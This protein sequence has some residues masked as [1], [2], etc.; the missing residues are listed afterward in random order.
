MKLKRIL[1]VLLA[2][3]LPLHACGEEA[4]SAGQVLKQLQSGEYEAVRRSLDDAMKAALSERD[5]AGLLPSL[6]ASFGK[7]LDTGKETAVS[8]P[9]YTVVSLPLRYE[10]GQL[11]FRVSWADGKIAGMHFSV[12]SQDKAPDESLPDGLT[13][14]AVS[15]G[16][17]AL[18]G[19]LT[20]PQKAM[21]PLPA[22][23]LLHG[24]GPNDRDETI[25]QTK[26]FRDLAWGLSQ[27]GIAVLRYDKRTLAYGKDY[28]KEQLA[29]LTVEEEAIDDALLAAELLRADPR[30]DPGR[31]YLLGHSLGAS[32]APRT[33]RENPGVFAW[34]ILL[35]GTPLTLADIVLHQNRAAAGQAAPVRR[36]ILFLQINGMEREW[37][38]IRT[39]TAEAAKE[40]TFAGQPA[41]YFWDLARHDVGEDLAALSLPA[42]IING[43]RDF[44]IPDADGID[45]WRA[46]E[47]PDTVTVLH[48]PALNHL[49][50]A[51]D[52]PETARG[53]VREYDVPCHAAED[54]IEDIAQFI[55]Q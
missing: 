10:K 41:Y 47:L 14:E 50:M 8:S 52:A 24:S 9:P 16:S 44:Q 42:L 22:V 11:L 25:G 43:G 37:Q 13:E 5:L 12:T 21:G 55:L 2:L 23:V 45:A 15:V 26:L 53:T 3:A 54:V 18:P 46:L 49:L 51:P 34:L 19:V 27:K 4:R 36:Q 31:V 32:I 1:C 38:A 17:P 48:K 29:A 28:T 20:L 7:L 35:S 40:K 30:I 6:E 33:A 39:G